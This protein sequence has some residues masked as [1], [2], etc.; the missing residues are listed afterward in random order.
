MRVSVVVP[1]YNKGSY[2]ERALLSI[3]S[4]TLTDIEAIVVDDGSTDGG[5]DIAAAFPDR[6]FRTVRQPNAGPGAAR[7]RGISETSGEIVAFLDAD[8]AWASDYLET[9]LQ[10]LE[11]Y[12]PEVAALTS[13]YVVQ[14]ENISSVPLWRKRG[15]ETGVHRITPH[16]SCHTLAHLASCMTS[17]TTIFRR[18]AI[19]RGGGYYSKDCCKYA[20][21]VQLCLKILLNEP[22]ALRPEPKVDMDYSASS[23]GRNFAGVRPIE[24]CL[25]DPEDAERVCPPEL[26]PL[27]RRLYARWA[28]KTAAVLGAWGNTARARSLVRQYV[29]W[30]NADPAFLSI[31][32]VGCTP[33]AP[34][35][36]RAFLRSGIAAKQ[37]GKGFSAALKI[38]SARAGR[39]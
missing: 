13:G 36:G 23:L 24:P 28:C 33:L 38:N 7:N 1:L 15:L 16:T 29:R 9:G 3:A 27:L 31:A 6:R 20:E 2:I 12:G 32:L 18:A 21:D 11:A 22:V 25:L 10:L 34:L 14:P 35:L 30:N 17:S 5:G 37:R 4:Q 8:D 39:D 26:R 19:L